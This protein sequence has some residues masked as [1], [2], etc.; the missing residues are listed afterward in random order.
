MQVDT[1]KE[2]QRQKDY[3]IQTMSEKQKLFLS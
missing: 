3:E 1:L 2:L